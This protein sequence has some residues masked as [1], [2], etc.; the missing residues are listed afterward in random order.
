MRRQSCATYVLLD[1]AE[2][3]WTHAIF[4]NAHALLPELIIFFEWFVV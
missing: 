3:L 2:R 1:T 4:L